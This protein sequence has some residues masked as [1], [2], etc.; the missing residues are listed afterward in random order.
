MQLVSDGQPLN[1]V[2][3]NAPIN[4]L[5]RQALSLKTSVEDLN[6]KSGRLIFSSAALGTET[7]IGDLVYFDANNKVFRPALGDTYQDPVK[8]GLIAG[9]RSRVVGLVLSK[10]S[11]SEGDLLLSGRINLNDEG[12][13]L[14]ALLDGFDSDWFSSGALYLS[15][16]IPGKATPNR[17][18]PS[19]Q[20]GFF[21]SGES[22][23]LLNHKDLFES[24]E[25]YRFDLLT[26]PSASQ[27]YAQ[28]GWTSFGES[29]SGVKK[30]VDY[31]NAGTSITPPPVIMCVRQ[32]AGAAPISPLNPVRV[33][34]YNNGGLGIF[35]LSGS[36]AIAS[37]LGS[38]DS[39][40]D[41]PLQPWPSY[42]DWVAIE[43]TNLEI[44][45]VRA[46]N[47]Y[48]TTLAADAETYLND[49]NYRFK[50]F[51]PDDLSG[52]TN[53]NTFDL[54]HPEGAVYRYLLDYDTKLNGVFPPLPTDSSI[55]ELNGVSI[56]PQTDFSVTHL[57][58][59]WRN[60]TFDVGDMSPWPS[61][62]SVA[63]PSSM[64]LDNAKTIVLSFIKSAL[65]GLNSV[66]YSLK[67]IAPIKVSRCPDSAE[68]QNGDLQVEVDLNLTTSTTPGTSETALSSVSG[69]QFEK[70][71][72]VSELVAGAGIQLE[73]ITPSA[74][75]PGKNCGLVRISVRGL[76]FEG[77]MNS[78]SLR[79]AKEV[80]SP[81][82][83]Y[84]DFIPPSV[85]AS[86]ITAALKFPNEDFTPSTTKLYVLGQFRGDTDVPSASSELF[87]MFKVVYHVLRPG[88]TMSAMND[89]NAIA[90]QYWR[91]PFAASYAATTILPIE[92]PYLAGTPSN[93]EINSGTLVSNPSSLVALSGGFQAG[94]RVVVLID[95]TTQDLSGNTANYTGRV[96]LSGLRWFLK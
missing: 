60:G 37:P 25:H 13:S 42:G 26:K 94:D 58:I 27:N 74:Q 71:T 32:I 43:G 92:Y 50:I 63:S 6:Q 87:A 40:I 86:G 45:F 96:G 75:I 14:S 83:S 22:S 85:G 56:S 47:T 33:E 84:I 89:S 17:V 61:D 38:A 12:M 53:C 76:K 69:V 72:M 78:I 8:G 64:I 77:E 62:Y 67:G 59:F 52:W 9:P 7:L 44:S 79:N 88:F 54:S 20:L 28:T 68:A 41:F 80:L 5:E 19:I 51:L 15:T 95:R 57:G 31:F 36:I 55:I 49:T 23:V 65:S 16:R 2:T 39:E 66:V 46:D 93:F 4:D 90:V 82:G 24:H 21:S 81:V 35:V 48:S 18:F 91:I 70:A 11:I 73:N 30:R 34:I 10:S 1:Q 3:L 29:G